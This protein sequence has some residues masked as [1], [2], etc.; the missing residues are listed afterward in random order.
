MSWYHHGVVSF[1]EVVLFSGPH[2]AKVLSTEHQLI[3]I[4][5]FHFIYFCELARAICI[6]NG[7]QNRRLFW[8][9]PFLRTWRMSQKN[10]NESKCQ[11]TM[12]KKP[13][14][15]IFMAASPKLPYQRAGFLL[16]VTSISATTELNWTE[17]CFC[18]VPRR[19]RRQARVITWIFITP[20]IRWAIAEISPKPKRRP[21][22]V[23]RGQMLAFAD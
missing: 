23:S 6:W 13:L 9:V 19:R 21:R 14:I 10:G 16:F 7:N 12:G 2:R 3:S 15:C 11:Q 8:L 5:D 18:L 22:I 4:I 20:R 17:F 1:F